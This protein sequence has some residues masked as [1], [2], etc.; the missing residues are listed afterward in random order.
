MNFQ[1]I[2]GSLSFKVEFST[3]EEM[4]RFI[5]M[6]QSMR[7]K[8]DN[9]AISSNEPEAE[10][11]KKKAVTHTRIETYNQI[12]SLLKRQFGN[13]VFTHDDSIQLVKEQLEYEKSTVRDALA[14]AIDSKILFRLQKG[15][16]AFE[17]PKPF[18]LNPDSQMELVTSESMALLDAFRVVEKVCPALVLIASP[19]DG[20]HCRLSNSENTEAIE[21]K[22]SKSIFST[23]H[24]KQPLLL[25]I[26]ARSFIERISRV[27][28]NEQLHVMIPSIEVNSMLIGCLGAEFTL[29][30]HEITNM[31][32]QLESIP[33]PTAKAEI[34]IRREEFARLLQDAQVN[35][36]YI[37]IIYESDKAIL[38][39]VSEK[40]DFKREI[41]N[42]YKCIEP[43][44][45][46][47]SIEHLLKVIKASSC[48]SVILRDSIELLTV[49]FII[50]EGISLQFM[51]PRS[52][53][54]QDVVRNDNNGNNV[55]S[56]IPPN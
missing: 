42:G 9:A 56:S 50:K 17:A 40:G 5:S 37:D 38:T 14:Y 22:I 10:E 21:L 28:S 29:R 18:I 25:G 48:D 52:Q 34:T 24:V 11:T 41:Q 46:R 15:E 27:R 43:T 31:T 6:V 23:Y 30:L 55:I 49:D 7:G 2:K 16:Y 8:N 13:R 51:L 3:F 53:S 39:N 12:L 45:A 33:I 4:Q 44:R 26:D 54:K 35:A 36:P 1:E 32:K 19:E 47:Y 20:L